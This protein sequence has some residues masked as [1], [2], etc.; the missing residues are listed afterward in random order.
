[1][2]A[3]VH[4]MPFVNNKTAVRVRALPV[5]RAAAALELGGIVTRMTDRC[6]SLTEL[7]SVMSDISFVVHGMELA[8]ERFLHANHPSF[9]DKARVANLRTEITNYMQARA[10]EV[11]E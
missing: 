7:D 11:G 2:S 8:A 3:S 9:E 4:M 5:C 10:N 1:M 6:V